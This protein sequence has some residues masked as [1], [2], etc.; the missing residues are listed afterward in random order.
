MTEYTSNKNCRSNS[1]SWELNMQ[2]LLAW[3]KRRSYYVDDRYSFKEKI[4]KG[5]Y[6]M[7][8]GADVGGTREPSFALLNRR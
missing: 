8:I 7:V 6:S 5:L 3:F 2:T 4:H 1:H